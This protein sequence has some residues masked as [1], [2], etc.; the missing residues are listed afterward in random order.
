[1]NVLAVC[2]LLGEGVQIG[3]VPH[4]AAIVN[5]LNS[6]TATES[7]FNEGMTGKDILKRLG[8]IAED[9]KEFFTKMVVLAPIEIS[10]FVDGIAKLRLVVNDQMSVSDKRYED[11]VVYFLF[12]TFIVCVVE[13]MRYIFLVTANGDNVTGAMVDVTKYIFEYI[14]NDDI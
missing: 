9:D 2:E 3:S 6:V 14:T 11:Y 10:E 13:V 12:L 1:M 8:D 7:I 4:G 5:R